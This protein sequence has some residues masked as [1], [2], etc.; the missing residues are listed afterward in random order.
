MLAWAVF[1]TVAAVSGGAALWVVLAGQVVRMTVGLLAALVGVALCFLLLGAEF[2]GAAQ[3]AVYVGG[4]LVLLV[5]GGMLTAGGP[6]ATLPPRRWEW[7][8][9]GAL[10]V[11]LFALIATVAVRLGDRPAAD[12]LPGTAPLGLTL[13]G[14]PER[15]G[16]VA[17]LLPFEAVSVHLL[18][19]LVGAAYLARAER[20]P[21]P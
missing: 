19:C 21:T 1:L 8:A 20:R 16:G 3:L 17:Y 2:L 7:V 10:A 6:R 12:P 18:V 14:V 15:P 9:G 11:S 4:T 5:F 13:L